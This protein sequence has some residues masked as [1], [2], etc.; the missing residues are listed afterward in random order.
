MF[1]IS[2]NV[3]C[4]TV[5]DEGLPMTVKSLWL[6]YLLK[7]GNGSAL[8]STSPFHKMFHKYFYENLSLV[9]TKMSC[10]YKNVL[11]IGDFN[12][13][14]ENKN[15]EVFMNTLDLECLIKEPTCFQSTSPSCIDLILTNKKEF[16]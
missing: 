8:V 15:L 7:V 6:N 3:P 16:F 12:L 10:E 9:L 13:T 1:Y 11:L 4:K 14:V 2:E 5:N